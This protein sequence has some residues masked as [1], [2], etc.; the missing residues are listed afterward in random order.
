MKPV[1]FFLL[2]LCLL[3]Y[4]S[5]AQLTIYGGPQVSTAQYSI[6]DFSQETEHKFGFMGGVGLKSLIEGPVYFS[7]MLF[8][9]RKGYKVTFDR[10]AYP[11][12]SVAINNNTTIN[13][14]ELAPLVQINFSSQASYAFF[15]FGPSFDFNI[16]G[17]ETYDSLNNKSRTQKML[18][19]FGG[20][21]HA[22]IAVNGHL[23][24]QHK[25]GFTLFAFAN[26]GIS[27]LN[28]ADKGPKIFH[29]VGGV[30]LGW[31]FGKKR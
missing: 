27:S 18:F 8:F 4:A 21:S 28:N 9:S 22:T 16:S 14:I 29:R 2:L 5:N 17:T 15:R 20:Y 26:I 19:D 7:P 12:D 25:S 30:A 10:A 13:T 24:Y 6:R 1:T 3:N 11:P 23:G 31:K